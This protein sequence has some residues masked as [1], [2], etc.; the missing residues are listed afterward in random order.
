MKKKSF[1]FSKM[2]FLG[3]QVCMWSWKSWCLLRVEEISEEQ[4]CLLGLKNEDAD[5]VGPDEAW[6]KLTCYL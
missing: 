4:E 5:I 1:T 3:C 2:S 6:M